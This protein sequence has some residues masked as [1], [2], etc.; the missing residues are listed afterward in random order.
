MKTDVLLAKTV[1]LTNTKSKLS[2]T[3]SK[4]EAM[5]I[6][7]L[8]VSIKC[9]SSINLLVFPLTIACSVEL[10]K[11]EK[12]TTSEQAVDA[13]STL[14]TQL[15]LILCGAKCFPSM[16]RNNFCQIF[17]QNCAVWKFLHHLPP[18]QFAP[19]MSCIFS[20]NLCVWGCVLKLL[21]AL[22]CLD[23]PH[24]ERFILCFIESLTHSYIKLLASSQPLC[25]VKISSF[26][27]DRIRFII[28]LKDD[29]FVC[30]ILVDDLT[31]SLKTQ[32]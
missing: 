23:P 8:Y 16:S 32:I 14:N 19:K 10:V 18:S 27:T 3:M 7:K 29:R 22:L 21:F 15:M 26:D 20:S 25:V 24:W 28:L 12:L 5:F 17:F 1:K 4:V 31:E 2:L 13:A 11:N 9:F 6:K 30:V